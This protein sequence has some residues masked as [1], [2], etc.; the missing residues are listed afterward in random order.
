MTAKS[1]FAVLAI[2]LCPV[3]A[4]AQLEVGTATA[5]ITPT[6]GGRMYGYGARGAKTSSGVHDALMARAL[7]AF[8]GRTKVALVTLDLGY[9]D[10]E[11][12]S[13]VRAAVADAIGLD[14]V[15]I[16][17]SHTHSGPAL[18]AD[19][20]SA[21]QPGA[22]AVDG[23]SAGL[24]YTDELVQAIAGAVVEADTNRTPA[25]L[26]AGWGRLEEGHN[27]RRVLPD[28]TVEMRW[29]NRD[30]RPTN[31][32]DHAI[33]VLAFD[34]LAGVPIATLV[35]FACHPV[36]LGPENLRLSADYPGSLV[37]MVDRLVGGQTMFLQGAAGDINPFWDKTPP[38]EGAFE[39]AQRMGEALAREVVRVRADVTGYED[40]PWVSLHR[41]VVPLGTR[42]DT[43]D[44]RVQAGVGV[45]AIARFERERDAEIATLLFGPSV[46]IAMF[47]GEFFVE[48][49]L[50]L[51]QQSTVRHTL[52]VGYANGHAGYFPTIR[53]AA[54]GGYGADSSTI[55]ELGAGE[56]LVNRALINLHF[57]AG[58]LSALP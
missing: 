30:R 54:E 16:T 39:E 32:V 4:R 1:V 43:G 18:A 50:Q 55:I 20:Q 47:P 35:N 57:Q 14:D 27:R 11:V 37:A 22:L 6:P 31:P 3:P 51:K 28:G 9:I 17:A 15:L 44:A 56:H 8:D 58:K 52:F 24:P 7:V 23:Q 41:D 48:H 40:T 46:A 19:G 29:A 33:G 38:A 12:T 49:G 45:D 25:K 5:D 36:V 2:L 21:G 53:A 26:A 34:S 13:R 42:W 10:T